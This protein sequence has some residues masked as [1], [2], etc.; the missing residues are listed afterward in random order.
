MAI[1]NITCE[2]DADFYRQFVYQTTTGAPIDLTGNTM[3]MGVRARAEDVTEE[4]LLTT[5]NGGLTIVSAP[6]GTFTVRI[7]QAQLV[8]L[9]IG[10]YEHSLIR[11]TPGPQQLRIWSGALTIN[12]G[13]SR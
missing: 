9:P 13:A 4:L 11:I 12:A 10:D 5:E 3:R 2:N 1:V 6:D 7:T 8:V